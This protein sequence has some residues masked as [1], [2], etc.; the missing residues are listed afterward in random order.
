MDEPTAGLDPRSAP[1]SPTLLAETTREVTVVIP[2]THIVS[3]VVNLCRRMAVSGA[4]ES[5]P[6]ARPRAAVAG[7]DGSIWEAVV[8]REQVAGP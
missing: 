7:L 8:E 6:R 4:A 1:A 3:T 2:S 5:S